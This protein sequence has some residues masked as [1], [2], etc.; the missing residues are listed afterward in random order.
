MLLSALLGTY[1]SQPKF[2]SDLPLN[3]Q[4]YYRY[5]FDSA[6]SAN[7][8]QRLSPEAQAQFFR[9]SQVNKF[10]YDTIR[11]KASFWN[12]AVSQSTISDVVSHLPNSNFFQSLSNGSTESHGQASTRRALSDLAQ[13]LTIQFLFQQAIGQTQVNS[14]ILLSDANLIQ[15]KKQTVE[16]SKIAPPTNS[17]QGWV[18][19]EASIAHY[20]EENI[21]ASPMTADVTVHLFSANNGINLEAKLTQV[22]N[23][24]LMNPYHFVPTKPSDWST[25]H[26]KSVSLDDQ[27]VK[28]VFGPEGL[29]QLAKAYQQMD[30]SFHVVNDAQSIVVFSVSRFTPGKRP[31]IDSQRQHITKQLTHEN[32]QRVYQKHAEKVVDQVNN[33]QPLQP[34][35]IGQTRRIE[36]GSGNIQLLPSFVQKALGANI[37]SQHSNKALIAVDS[38]GHYYL[39]RLSKPEFQTTTLKKSSVKS[40]SISYFQMQAELS[41]LLAH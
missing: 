39:V 10:W 30:Q 14:A 5:Q 27:S 13:G 29:K 6:V 19:S 8:N 3:E 38:L 40:S 4:I 22:S 12:M 34:H 21:A 20:Y 15:S 2:E 32:D 35:L 16:W 18:P 7:N 28:Y 17:G 36:I 25:Q 9:Q 33:K 37:A 41:Q 24:I 31:S 11:N 1:L 23:A 26:L